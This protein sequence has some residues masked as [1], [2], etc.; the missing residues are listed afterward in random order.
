[1]RGVEEQVVRTTRLAAGTVA[2]S[3]VGD[4]PPVVMGGWWCSHLTLNW[5]DPTFRDYVSRLAADHAVVRYDPP[6]TGASG[7]DGRVPRTLEDAVEVMAGVVDALG[8][9]RFSIAAGSSGA[10]AAAA[11]T[12]M[13]PGQVRRLVL[14][15]AF[16]RGRDIAPDDARDAVVEVIRSHWGLGSRVLADVFVP[17]ATSAERERFARLQR[18]SATREQAAA[19]MEATYQL[20]VTDRLGEIRTPT[21]VIHRRGDRAVPFAL[22]ADVARRIKGSTFVALEGVDHFPWRGD[23]TL[24]AEAVLRGLGRHVP[25]KP[26]LPGPESITPRE[27]E[28]LELVAQGLTDAQIAERLVVSAHTVHRHIANART[29]LGVRSRS[30]AAVTMARRPR[31]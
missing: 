17:G 4:G 28:V 15:G 16:A 1:M 14:Y 31:E 29:K 7:P 18:E 24:V 9:D 21:T 13:H 22:G 2:Y 23:A 20:D 30:A 26:D 6:G 8:L 27:R 11:Y 5:Q 25:E 19:S 3:V 10:G 12:A